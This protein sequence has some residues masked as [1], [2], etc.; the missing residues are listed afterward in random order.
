M[1]S[2]HTIQPLPSPKSELRI[3][4]DPS[5]AAVPRAHH[6]LPDSA[7]KDHAVYP[8][9]LNS[10]TAAKDSAPVSSLAVIVLGR[11]QRLCPDLRGGV[12]IALVLIGFRFVLGARRQLCL[13]LLPARGGVLS[14]VWGSCRLGGR[15]IA[16][17]SR[18][19]MGLLLG[20]YLVRLHRSAGWLGR[21]L[22]RDLGGWAVRGRLSP[23]LHRLL[24]WSW[25]NRTCSCGID[26]RWVGLVL[27]CSLDPLPWIPKSSHFR[28]KD[29]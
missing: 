26:R 9:D 19:H 18:F 4:S 2:S 10:P 21:S 1:S 29:C 20:L 16:P 8:A 28:W 22:S 5:A 14:L 7:A 12:V 24:C 3:H 27:L 23:H 13:C 6:G 11:R 17:S 25:V 15:E